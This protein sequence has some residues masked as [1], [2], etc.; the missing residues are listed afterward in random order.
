[1]VKLCTVCGE[2]KAVLR[3]PKTRQ[4]TCRECFFRLLEDEVHD[5]ITRHKLFTRGD[6]LAI[7]ASGGK[8]STVLA[9]MLTTLNARHDYGLDLFLLSVDEGIA[10]YRDD[11]LET[12]KRNEAQYGIPLVVVTY[13]QLYGWT[14]D[15][16]V[17]AVGQKNNCTFCGV[18]RRQALD[19]GAHLA[20]ATV[21][22]TGHNADDVAETVL[23]NLVRGDF[24]RLGRCTAIITGEGGSLPRVK[25]FKYT[26]EK[27]IV[28]YAYF[29]KLDYFSTECIYSP[30]AYRGFAREFVKD[31]EAAR[32]MAIIDIIRSGEAYAT[33]AEGLE[34]DE[35]EGGVGAVMGASRGGSSGADASSKAQGTPAVGSGT[36][37]KPREPGLCQQC[38]YLSSQA[39]CKACVLL[40]GLNRGLPTLGLARNQAKAKRIIASAQ[41]TSQVA[42]AT[43]GSMGSGMGG[44][45]G[46]S[47]GCR[48]ED[49]PTKQ[50]GMDVPQRS[51]G[52]ERPAE[53]SINSHGAAEVSVSAGAAASCVPVQGRPVGRAG[54]VSIGY[55]D[56]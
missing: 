11:S 40:D 50:E 8:D 54:A 39:R 25:P 37:Q 20:G 56:L 55:D 23:L 13:K 9:H 51:A 17:R 3:R 48:G 26:Y 16:I 43:D 1:M 31:L 38:G 28:M 14:M 24:A 33:E 44:S 15:E 42:T 47:S 22:A 41:E 35:G 7:A 12:V 30:F 6:R 10:G 21:M 49:D 36:A 27:E 4:E 53:A 2:A 34:G 45:S 46:S 5:A 52:N 19:R 18:F 29:K 32:P